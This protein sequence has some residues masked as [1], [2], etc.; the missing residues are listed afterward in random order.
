MCRRHTCPLSHGEYSGVSLS[1]PRDH[2]ERCILLVVAV[3]EIMEEWQRTG[4]HGAKIQREA[5]RG[6]G[7]LKSNGSVRIEICPCLAG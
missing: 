1:R 2:D 7:Q 5:G 3:L 4:V 6:C